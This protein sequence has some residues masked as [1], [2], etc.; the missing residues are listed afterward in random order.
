MIIKDKN[1]QEIEIFVYGNE[2][3]DIQI[4]SATY[5]DTGLDV[6]DDIIDWILEHY[7]DLI[8]ENWMDRMIMRAENFKDSMEDR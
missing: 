7:S 3:D 8:Y 1:N 6:P 5:V 2:P 4:E